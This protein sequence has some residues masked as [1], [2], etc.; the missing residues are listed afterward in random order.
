MPI[1]FPCLLPGALCAVL[2]FACGLAA[3]AECLAPIPPERVTDPAIR[4]DYHAEISAEYS[5]YFDEVQAYLRCLDETRT[6]TIAEVNQ[7]LADYQSLGIG[8]KH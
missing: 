6:A 3:D 1:L 7:V 8:G 5:A 4:A 2:T